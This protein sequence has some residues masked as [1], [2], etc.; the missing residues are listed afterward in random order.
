MHLTA[1]GFQG[2]TAWA[3]P[4]PIAQMIK[5]LPVNAGDAGLI[6]GSGRFPGGGNGK[7][8][9]YSC[10]ENSMAMESGRLQS[11]G[12]KRAGH[13]L[14]T[15]QEEHVHVVRGDQRKTHTPA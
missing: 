14:A 2:D 7:P 15:K 4:S 11:M 1:Q 3:W 8:L 6:L 13:N 10:L 5:N 9:Q 12:H